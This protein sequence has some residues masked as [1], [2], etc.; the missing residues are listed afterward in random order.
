[1]N[2]YETCPEVSNDRFVLRLVRESDC[3]DLLKVYSDEAA[4]PLFN[5]D[6][7][8]GD[9]PEAAEEAKKELCTL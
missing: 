6:N 7:C 8:N 2:V 4:V 1:M 3:A 5:S 9:A